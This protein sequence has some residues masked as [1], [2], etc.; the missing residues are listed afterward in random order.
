MQSLSPAQIAEIFPHLPERYRRALSEAG[1]GGR[2][3][4]ICHFCRGE[5]PGI[6]LGGPATICPQ[7]GAS[8]LVKL[9]VFI[10]NSPFRIGG[11][12]VAII[13]DGKVDSE[14]RL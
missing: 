9:P 3:V 4:G 10:D 2:V 5:V 6:L 1:Y 13:R 14:Q 8:V 12:T 11:K 7:C